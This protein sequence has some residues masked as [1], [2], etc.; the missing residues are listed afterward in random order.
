MRPRRQFHRPTCL[1][2]AEEA[3]LHPRGLSAVATTPGVTRPVVGIA[4]FPRFRGQV[5]V[6]RPSLSIGADQEAREVNKKV[7][8]RN[9]DPMGLGTAVTVL[10]NSWASK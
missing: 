1:S 6:L 3:V 7:T 5:N 2:L 4:E 10:I 9:P 8:K